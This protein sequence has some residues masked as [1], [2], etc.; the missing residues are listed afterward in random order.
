MFELLKLSFEIIFVGCG[1]HVYKDIWEVKISSE[2]PFLP[3][4]NNHE[5]RHIAAIL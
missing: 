2:L 1:Y 4:P 5:D 3:K